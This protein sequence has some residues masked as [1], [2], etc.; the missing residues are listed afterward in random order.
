M[1]SEIVN[2]PPEPSHDHLRAVQWNLSAQ[3]VQDPQGNEY[4]DGVIQGYDAAYPG[5]CY[6]LTHEEGESIFCRNFRIINEANRRNILEAVI[7][8]N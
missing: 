2:K 8:E 4:S 1:R 7:S 6:K 5:N 3:Q